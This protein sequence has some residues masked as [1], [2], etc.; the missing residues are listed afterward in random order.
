[1]SRREVAAGRDGREIAAT[2]SDSRQEKTNEE[3][4]TVSSTVEHQGALRILLVLLGVPSVV[5]G[6]WAGFAPR[7][8]YDDFPARVVRGSLPMGRSTSTSFA[9]S[10][11]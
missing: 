10:E 1:M 9:T 8:F 5:I 3:G 7:G 6:L 11:C 4:V 2:V